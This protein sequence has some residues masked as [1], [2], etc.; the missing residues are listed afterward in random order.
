MTTA[1]PFPVCCAGLP[2]FWSTPPDAATRT[3]LHRFLTVSVDTPLVRYI[4][5]PRLI[6]PLAVDGAVRILTMVSSPSDVADLDVEAE[7]SRINDSL[8][9]L[10]SGGLIELQRLPEATM[11]ALQHE[12]RQ[13]SY[14]VFH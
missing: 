6:H 1:P 8:S 7:W 3:S 12:L 9:G 2:A 10:A 11:A 13:R 5:Q 14:H 4:Q